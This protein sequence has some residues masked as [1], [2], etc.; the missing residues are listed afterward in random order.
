[1]LTTNTPTIIETR[2]PTTNHS[3]SDIITL[4]NINITMEESDISWESDREERFKQP[5]GFV[6]AENGTDDCYTCETCLGGDQYSECEN[7]TDTAAGKSYFYWYPDND[8][9]RK[10]KGFPF[11]GVYFRYI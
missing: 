3:A 8:E 2:P 4:T 6:Y 1:M 7:Y 10:A 11:Y 5:P 9:V